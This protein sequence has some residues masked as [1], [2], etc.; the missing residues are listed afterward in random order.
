MIALSYI[1]KHFATRGAL[2]DYRTL[3]GVIDKRYEQYQRDPAVHATTVYQRLRKTA[4]AERKAD[5]VFCT[6]L[7]ISSGEMAGT[8]DVPKS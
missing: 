7:I 1:D 5:Q 2:R 3:L 4:G 8:A 6:R